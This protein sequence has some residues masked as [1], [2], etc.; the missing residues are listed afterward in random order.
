[1]VATGNPRA[2]FRGFVFCGLLIG[3]CFAKP[4]ADLARFAVGSDLF[5][6]VLLIPFVSA[7]FIW[8]WRAELRGA[9]PRG[10]FWAVVPAGLSVGSLCFYWFVARPGSHLATNDYLFLTTTAFL[11]LVWAAALAWLG[12]GMVGRLWFPLALL[13]FMVPWPTAAVDAVEVFLQHASAEAA[14]LFL[15]LSGDPVLRDGLAFKLPGISI[16]VGQECSGVHSSLVLLITSIVAGQLFFRSRWRRWVLALAVIPLGILRNGFRIFTISMLCV[17][18]N[19]NMIDSPIHHRGGPIFF[20]LSLV[21]FF[22]LLLWL[23][24]TEED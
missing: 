8:R 20:V 10:S 5:S 16:Q 15:G 1:V 22:A 11:G 9:E 19:P 2:R 3:V 17:H 6:H 4:I 24:K 14:G 12:T 7:Y 21:P 18:V 23:R 13:G